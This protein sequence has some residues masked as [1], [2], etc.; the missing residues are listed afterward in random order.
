MV[1]KKNQGSNFGSLD[2]SKP[3]D[4]N[5]HYNSTSEVIYFATD[6]TVSDRNTEIQCYSAPG[7]GGMYGLEWEVTILTESSIWSTSRLFSATGYQEPSIE[8]IDG[9]DN[10]PTAGSLDMDDVSI[11]GS[12]FGPM[13]TV[14]Q[15]KYQ[16]Q[17]GTDA[18]ES[19]VFVAKDCW[20]SLFIPGLQA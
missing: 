8:Q 6:C 20:V 13:G 1:I 9:S 17:E 11:I 15:A 2:P 7:I 18:I 4:V 5:V 12:N 16:Q 3:V 14:V 10:T 19:D